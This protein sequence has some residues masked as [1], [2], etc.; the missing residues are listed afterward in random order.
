MISSS[1]YF[2][3]I[4]VIALASGSGEIIAQANH[5]NGLSSTLLVF[6]VE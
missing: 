5:Q 4:S 2:H 6:S 3:L 1:P